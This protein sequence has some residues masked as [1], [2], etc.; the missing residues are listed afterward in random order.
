MDFCNYQ[1]TARQTAIYPDQY[2]IIYPA[3]GLGGQCG[4]VQEKVKKIIR[5]DNG[6]VSQ[7]KKEELKKELGDVLW[8]VANLAS[9]LGLNLDDIA[10]ENINKLLSRQERGVLQGSGDDR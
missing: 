8:Y 10:R 1:S 4:E 6:E 5:D 2:G 7:A 3:L 9:D